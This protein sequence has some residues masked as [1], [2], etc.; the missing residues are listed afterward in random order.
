MRSTLNTGSNDQPADLSAPNSLSRTFSKAQED[1]TKVVSKA[2]HYMSNTCF[3]LCICTSIFVWTDEKQK[4]DTELRKAL[5]EAEER[6]TT[7]EEESNEEVNS[8]AAG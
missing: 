7:R 1:F 2:L 6:A 5:R 8:K 3:D 4:V